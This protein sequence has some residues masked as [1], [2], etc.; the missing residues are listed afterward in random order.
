MFSHKLIILLVIFSLALQ[1]PCLVAAASFQSVKTNNEEQLRK[2]R[3]R[4]QGSFLYRYSKDLLTTPNGKITKDNFR[5][6]PKVFRQIQA[7]LSRSVVDIGQF[8]NKNLDRIK[9]VFPDAVEFPANAKIKLLNNTND[10]PN[11]RFV[12]TNENN[13]I[14]VSSKSI[15]KIIQATI[16]G[17]IA[18]KTL[19]NHDYPDKDNIAVVEADIEK[20]LKQF[21]NLVER[22]NSREF[23]NFIFGVRD[24]GLNELYS[25]AIDNFTLIATYSSVL[26]FVI[27]HEIGHIIL[28]HQIDANYKGTPDEVC[29]RRAMLETEADIYASYLIYNRIIPYN[30]AAVADGKHVLFPSFSDYFFNLVYNVAGFNEPEPGGCYPYPP[31]EQRIEASEKGKE[32]AYEVADESPIRLQVGEAARLLYESS[33]LMTLTTFNRTYDI[34]KVQLFVETGTLVRIDTKF[35]TGEKNENLQIGLLINNPNWIIRK[36]PQRTGLQFSNEGHF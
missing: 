28:R 16:Y 15:I 24:G 9:K 7:S 25:V 20:L 10:D 18:R 17:D 19:R 23:D 8:H 1:F 2:L 13:E 5:L 30:M 12:A 31:N 29:K 6:S 35:K 22:G 26:L 34:Y 11:R 33:Q 21:C 14:N 27:A 3:H 4:W 32:T 36:R